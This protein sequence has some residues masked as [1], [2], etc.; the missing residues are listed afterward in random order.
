MHIPNTSNELAY[1]AMTTGPPSPSSPSALDIP[2]TI[3]NS[4]IDIAHDIC[5]PAQKCGSLRA[6]ECGV[7]LETHGEIP[8]TLSS[9]HSRLLYLYDFPAVISLSKISE[10]AGKSKASASGNAST[11]ANRVK[12]QDGQ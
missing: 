7:Q 9:N 6:S 11:M 10:R 8:P 1:S 5:D 3:L 12:Q 4:L 2:S